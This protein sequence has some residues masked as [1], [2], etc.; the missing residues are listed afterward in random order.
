MKINK[1][2][3]KNEIQ[4]IADLFNSY[5]QTISDLT[6]PKDIPVEQAAVISVSDQLFAFLV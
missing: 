5:S 3:K 2:V 1:L 6:A 4:Y